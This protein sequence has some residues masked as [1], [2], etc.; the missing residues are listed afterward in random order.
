MNE[1]WSRYLHIN[2]YTSAMVD[3]KEKITSQS[4]GKKYNSLDVLVNRQQ[5]IEYLKSRK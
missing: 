1:N 4:F 5:A 2:I 3:K